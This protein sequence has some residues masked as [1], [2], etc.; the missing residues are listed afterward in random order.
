MLNEEF[1]NLINE[2]KIISTRPNFND[3][4]DYGNNVVDYIFV[5]DKIKV[6]DFKVI[7]TDISDHYPLMLNFEIID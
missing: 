4:R 3:G 5:N 1:K 2:Y 7:K 6:N